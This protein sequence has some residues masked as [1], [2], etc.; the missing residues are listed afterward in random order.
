MTRPIVTLE[1]DEH[2]IEP[3][4]TDGLK[5]T[6]RPAVDGEVSVYVVTRTDTMEDVQTFAFGPE[7]TGSIT[8]EV[9]R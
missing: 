6:I 7:S 1:L 8:I 5:M 2:R 3:V 9:S 4:E